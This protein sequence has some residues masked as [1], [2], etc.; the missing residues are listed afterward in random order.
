MSSI[1]KCALIL[2]LPGAIAG[3]AV[4]PEPLTQ[5]KIDE[6][7]ETQKASLA[8]DVVPPGGRI[9]L[10]EAIARAIKFN[11]D[12]R[13]EQMAASV[14]LAKLDVAN[15]QML[16]KVVASSDYFGRDNYAG[17]RSRSLITGRQSLEYSTSQDR[18][19]ASGDISFS[20]NILDFGL[21]YV[22][23]KQAADQAMRAD[24]QRRKALVRIIEDTR[25][26]YWRA[27]SSERLLARMRS[28]ERDVRGSLRNTR[29][30]SRNGLSQPLPA[31]TY[32]RELVAIKRE[33][34]QLERNLVV[35]RQQ[36]AALV[37]IAPGS[38]FRLHVPSHRPVPPVLAWRPD[39]M[40]DVA[41]RNRPEVR[42]LM[43]ENRI[44]QKEATAALL[45]ML[46]G[47]QVFLGPNVN[48]NSYLYKGNWVAWGAKASWNLMKVF[49]YPAVRGQVEM[50]D[51]L[52]RERALALTMAIMTQ[53]HVSRAKFANLAKEFHTAGEYRAVQR[54]L[55]N[56]VRGETA[57][58][59]SS[60]QNLIRERMNTI[61]ADAKYD[62]AYADLQNA[63][64]NI[65]ASIGVDFIDPATANRS[66]VAELKAQVDRALREAFRQRDIRTMVLPQPVAPQ[67]VSV[68]QRS[69]I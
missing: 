38:R 6:F 35:A 43:Y 19:Y 55:F 39:A 44:N 47:V 56:Q 25:T 3:C 18:S 58:E 24:E 69:G 63:Y 32:E 50:Q 15:W 52:N 67:K 16:P 20:Y 2:I 42:Q 64:G 61:V 10:T 26:A 45:E 13:V 1:K 57:A 14:A 5:A 12:H 34:Q 23:A 27:I 41:L 68:N 62:I 49:S 48:T 21:S 66:S 29:A 22:R 59:R 30:L 33:L 60:Q 4:T 40:V 53:V 54:R 17:S 28:L 37:N 31:L 65:L 11:L 51:G 7:A 36:L 46:P 9:D 8:A